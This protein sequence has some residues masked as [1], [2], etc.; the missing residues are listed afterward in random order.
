MSD[1]NNVFWTD[2]KDGDDKRYRYSELPDIDWDDD[3][4]DEMDYEEDENEEEDDDWDEEERLTT[5]S[6]ERR[7]SDGEYWSSRSKLSSE[8]TYTGAA[9]HGNFDGKTWKPIEYRL[10]ISIDVPTKSFS[11]L[12]TIYL[13]DLQIDG[14]FMEKDYDN[15]NLPIFLLDVILPEGVDSRIRRSINKMKELAESEANP[16]KKKPIITGTPFHKKSTRR[17]NSK[18]TFHIKFYGYCKDNPAERRSAENRFLIFNEDFVPMSVE[19]TP[20][21]ADKLNQKIH[22][23]ENWE[24]DDSR[25]ELEDRTNRKTY[26]LV[27]ER[28]TTM[29]RS[30]INAVIPK[31]SLTT[32]IECLFSGVDACEEVLL[33][34]LDNVIELEELLLLPVPLLSQLNYLNNYYGFHKEGTTMFFDFDMIYLIRMNGKRTAWRKNEIRENI[35]YISDITDSDASAEM[36]GVV[37]QGDTMYH[38]V[39]KDGYVTYNGSGLA[40]QIMGNNTLILDEQQQTQQFVDTGGTFYKTEVTRNNPYV[41]TWSELRSKEKECI[42]RLICTQVDITQF[43]PNKEYKILS[44]N[45]EVAAATTGAFRLCSVQH[46]LIKETDHFITVSIITL[47]RVSME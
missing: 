4:D 29:C 30:V 40:D 39:D 26:I 31:A 37:R 20:E 33:S 38:C 17:L 25:F 44:S 32:A 15:D 5:K 12:E 43:T 10:S 42:V 45:S 3:S 36:R 18:T 8:A 47:K 22:G 13:S 24:D 16:E 6:R 19:D 21:R 9:A 46:S 11:S 27:S 35:F 28:R 14:F 7:G 34:N 1:T 41:G 2:R 23:K